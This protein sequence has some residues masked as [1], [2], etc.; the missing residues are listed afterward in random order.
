MRKRLESD[1]K[2][3]KVEGD[4]RRPRVCF[5]HQEGLAGSWL[6][7]FGAG[8]QVGIFETWGQPGVDLVVPAATDTPARFAVF[9]HHFA[10]DLIGRGGFPAA[11]LEVEGAGFAGGVVFYFHRAVVVYSGRTGDDADDRRSHFLPGVEFLT[12]SGWAELEEPCTKG[13]DIK[14]FAVEFGLDG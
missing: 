5:P 11:R 4:V 12:T 9:G 10:A 7:S 8:G 2:G 6:L 14:G 13:V 1:D 3:R